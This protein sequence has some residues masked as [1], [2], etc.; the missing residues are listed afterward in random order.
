[1]TGPAPCG[2]GVI[3][4]LVARIGGRRRARL[5]AR[6]HARTGAQARSAI[7]DRI[8]AGEQVGA[9]PYGYRSC[10]GPRR[11]L[12]VDESTAAVVAQIFTWRA[13]DRIGATVIAR[14]L[15][16]DP[17][18]YPPPR[19]T[20]GTRRRWTRGTVRHILANPAYT[21]RRVWG[22]T[23]QGRPVPAHQWAAS[24]HDAHA[25]LIDDLTFHAAQRPLGRPR[26]TRG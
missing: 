14:R 11:R 10:D 16:A 19:D 3:G 7:A 24:A 8:R 13:T 6:H 21:G 12:A 18:R 26:S 2:Q 25:A 5:L 4:V 23:H 9:V 17:E 22:R 15:H 20:T 1:M